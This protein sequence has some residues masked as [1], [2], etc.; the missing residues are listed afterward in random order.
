MAG[1]AW[2]GVGVSTPSFRAP[3]VES[4]HFG[5]KLFCC[6]FLDAA[7]ARSMTGGSMAGGAWH[8]AGVSTPS[9]RAPVAESSHFGFKPFCC[10]FLDAATA[11]SMTGARALW[12]WGDYPRFRL[13]PYRNAAMRAESPDGHGQFPCR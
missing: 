1:G 3:V 9:F 11:R 10:D 4:S 6:D 13:W 5:I 7:T 12:R 8:G 2:H